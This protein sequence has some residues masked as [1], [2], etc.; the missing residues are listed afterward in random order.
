MER[1][2]TAFS[3]GRSDRLASPGE[4]QEAIITIIVIVDTWQYISNR[5]VLPEDKH[6]VWKRS[7]REPILGMC[8]YVTWH[9]RYPGLRSLRLCVL[10]GE[11]SPKQ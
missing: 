2:L 8:C 9:N 5:F 7:F 3:S 1:Y 10:L 6:I 11:I 4:Q